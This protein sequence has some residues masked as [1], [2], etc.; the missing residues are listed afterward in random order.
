MAEKTIEILVDLPP[1]KFAFVNGECVYGGSIIT[2]DQSK[3]DKCSSWMKRKSAP[4]PE[5]KNLLKK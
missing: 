4:K 5:Q 1:S 3:F 2:I